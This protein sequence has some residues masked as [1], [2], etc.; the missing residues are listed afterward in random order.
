MQRVPLGDDHHVLLGR[1]PEELVLDPSGFDR[2]WALH[3]EDKHLIQI[4]GR[5]VPTPRWQQAYGKDYRY[6]GQTNP[7]LPLT[8]EM[9][10]FLRWAQQRDERLNGLLFNW[11]D[12]QQ[13]HYIGAHRDSEIGRVEG[14]D[15]VTLS[16]G[17]TRTFRMR[18]WKGKGYVDIPVPHGSVV[19]IPWL[20]NRAWTHEVPASKAA[21]GRR[22]SITVR[23][24]SA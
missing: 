10:P 9:Q 8:E 5:L 16:F 14:T 12:G 11:Y 3:P 24:F 19:V 21:V 23:A 4:H 15:I 22:I 17:E 18:P 6:T 7:G 1:L 13:G 20:T 2:L